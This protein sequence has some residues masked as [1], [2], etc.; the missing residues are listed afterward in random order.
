[1]Y[2]LAFAGAG[3]LVSRQEDAAGVVMPILMFVIAAWFW[4]FRSCPPTRTTRSR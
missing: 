4:G 3:A 1:M 2:S